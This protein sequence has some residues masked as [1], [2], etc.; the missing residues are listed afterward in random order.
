MHT[1]GANSWSL[2]ICVGIHFSIE[3]SSKLVVDAILIT[4]K[5]YKHCLLAHPITNC[6]KFT[7]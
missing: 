1:C 5:Y 6:N 2:L 7:K 3:N 4:E